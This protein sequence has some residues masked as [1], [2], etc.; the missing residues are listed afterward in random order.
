MLASINAVLKH[1]ALRRLV[2]ASIGDGI[3]GSAYTVALGVY[4]FQAGGAELLG[5]AAL[6]RFLPQLLAAP[7]FSVAA[8]RYARERVLLALEGGRALAIL[9]A[10]LLI[11]GGADPV[12]P[13]AF[14]A[15]S[16]TL[17]GGFA[18]IRAAMLPALAGSRDRLVAANL[19][20][21]A[22][23]NAATFL[24]PAVGAAILVVAGPQ[25]VFY[26]TAAAL[27]SA[28]L[29]V[30]RCRADAR[31]SLRRASRSSSRA[32]GRSGGHRGCASSWPCTA[33]RRF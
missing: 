19:V 27:A 24:G 8:D 2:V 32:T 6:A 30:R 9:A 11:A 7:L 10:G 17:S 1:G 18:P 12:L 31:R 29:L 15:L 16:S 13:L 14:S 5:W 33:H 25:W 22:I 4:A 23:D 21:T 26:F 28:T 3:G 20:T